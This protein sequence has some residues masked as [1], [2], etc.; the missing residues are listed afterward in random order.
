[1]VLRVHSE[2][3]SYDNVEPKPR[4]SHVSYEEKRG[5]ERSVSE[6]ERS[7]MSYVL[8]NLGR[9]TLKKRESRAT[10]SLNEIQKNLTSHGKSLRSRV[11]F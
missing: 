6:K 3:H 4:P 11:L 9:E 5:Y 10:V 1:M 8:N 2:G 7:S